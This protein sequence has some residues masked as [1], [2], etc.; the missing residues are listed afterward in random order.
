MAPQDT[1]NLSNSMNRM[2]AVHHEYDL[3][4]YNI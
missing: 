2:D 3:S 4:L 1:I